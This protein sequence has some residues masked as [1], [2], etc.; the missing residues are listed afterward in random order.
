MQ[1]EKI[2]ELKNEILQK[3]DRIKEVNS[4]IE[5]LRKTILDLQK[6]I[7]DLKM[8]SNYKKFLEV[9]SK[10]E[11]ASSE[12]SSIK[13][14]IDLQFSKISRPLG[15]YSYISSF[16]KPVK[17]LMD[18]IIE[19]PYQAI[20]VQNKD[21]IILILE[22]VSKSVASSAI[23]VKDTDKALE[24]IQET[25]S[26]LDEFISLKE[27]YT[28]KIANL[29]NDLTVFDMKQLETKEHNLQKA[30]SDLDIAETT[31]KKLGV[32]INEKNNTLKKNIEEVERNLESVTNSK[33]TLKI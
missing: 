11:F 10:I 16:E 12:K 23:S 8:T 3:N 30:I 2:L 32:E 9:R 22:A 4:E 5:S 17:K 7:N 1:S 21:T 18:D 28:N 27:S 6:Q 31:V 25:I 33:I 20:S 24:Y 19:D 26:K 15:K 13:N 14:I 29:E